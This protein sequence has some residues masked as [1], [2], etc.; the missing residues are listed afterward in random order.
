MSLSQDIQVSQ[1]SQ[2]Q[3]DKSARQSKLCSFKSDMKSGNSRIL[4][5]YKLS[6]I[7]KITSVRKTSLIRIIS[8]NNL[9]PRKNKK[10]NTEFGFDQLHSFYSSSFTIIA[11]FSLLETSR[12]KNSK[13]LE[14]EEYM[15]D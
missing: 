8:I 5:H 3:G 4:V 13:M 12:C 15:I 7:E 11:A 14:L 2:G 9:F 1:K 10:K 6:A